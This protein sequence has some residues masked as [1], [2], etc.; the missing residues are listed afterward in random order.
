MVQVVEDPKFFGKERAEGGNEERDSAN[1]QLTAQLDAGYALGNAIF[2]GEVQRCPATCLCKIEPKLKK[3]KSEGRGWGSV[4]V[5]K[6]AEAETL[7]MQVTNRDRMCLYLTR[8]LSICVLYSSVSRCHSVYRYLGCVVQVVVVSRRHYLLARSAEPLRFINTL[9][10][11]PESLT[12]A[13]KLAVAESFVLK[14]IAMNSF[15]VRRAQPAS[16]VYLVK[17]GHLKILLQ[18][19]AS[20]TVVPLGANHSHRFTPCSVLWDSTSSSPGCLLMLMLCASDCYCATTSLPLFLCLAATVLFFVLLLLHCGL[21]LCCAPDC[22]S[23]CLPLCSYRIAYTF[24][25]LSALVDLTRASTQPAD[26]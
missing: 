25:T 13:T 8:C 23:T 26:R 15:L 9:P 20:H 5:A 4:R 21:L 16:L 6:V 1:G 24:P 11:F 2:S 18:V 10:Y 3:G 12:E 14:S 7:S 19:S 22:L 17:S